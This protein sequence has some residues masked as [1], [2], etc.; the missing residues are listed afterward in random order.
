MSY[1]F[2][3]EDEV[4]DAFMRLPARQREL[5]F[6]HFQCLADESPLPSEVSH[7]DSLGRP[8]MKRDFSGWTI[9]YWHDGAVKEVRI[10]DMERKRR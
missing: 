6:K 7:K 8:I 9:W 2:V 5:V 1:R 4:L 10:V 3:V